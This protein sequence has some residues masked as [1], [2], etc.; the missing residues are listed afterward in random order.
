M[1]IILNIIVIFLILSS[2]V[3]PQSIK[4]MDESEINDI[5]GDTVT[6]QF[7]PGIYHGWTE[8][9]IYIHAKNI[10]SKSIEL[11]AKKTEFSI[12]ADEYHSFCFAGNCF[13]SS[14]FISPYTEIV[15]AD[16]MDSSFSGHFYFDDLLHK[17][18]VSLVA[19]TFYDVNNPSD[20]SIVYVQYNTM[21]TIGIEAN[22]WSST[23]LFTAAPN[24]AYN[25]INFNYK[26]DKSLIGHARFIIT[27]NIGT[28]VLEQKINENNFEISLDI[29]KWASGIYFYTIIDGNNKIKTN[30]FIVMH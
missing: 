29:G 23:S 25:I 15:P 17:P 4:L 6:V 27:N 7:V 10:S 22:P 26:M 8:I 12:A 1:K 13:D 30:K 9:S 14:T 18:K 28:Q 11:G 20:S 5:T 2:T 19:Y 24:P 3:K 21:I 16:V